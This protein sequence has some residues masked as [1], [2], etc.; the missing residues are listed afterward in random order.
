MTDTKGDDKKKANVNAWLDAEKPAEPAQE[1]P[2][3]QMLRAMAA[4]NPAL[5]GGDST[6]KF[7]ANAKGALAGKGD[8]PVGSAPKPTAANPLA[9]VRDADHLFNVSEQRFAQ[10]KRELETQISLMQAKLAGMKDRHLGEM[11]DKLA[12]I[13]AN[14]SSVV[15]QASLQSYKRF[16]DGIGF[17]AQKFIERLRSK[18]K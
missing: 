5:K 13:D 15:T 12:E 8:T 16:L 7:I 10:E 18:R 9:G 11:M 17:S 6:A 2:S 3:G 4:I 14:L 1:G